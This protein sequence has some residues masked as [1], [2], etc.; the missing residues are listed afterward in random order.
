VIYINKKRYG[1][2]NEQK[3]EFIKVGIKDIECKIDKHKRKIAE[4]K[5]II[6]GHQL[7]LSNKK[8]ILKYYD[9]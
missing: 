4:L 9:P 7:M 8:R 2:T 5:A 1:T 3:K 6:K